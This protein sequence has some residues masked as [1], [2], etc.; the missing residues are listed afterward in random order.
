VAEITN[1]HYTAAFKKDGLYIYK[2]AKLIH[3]TSK[4]PDSTSWTLPIESPP[5]EANAVLSLP[6]DNKYL[7]FTHASFGSP[8]L[9]TFQRAIRKGYISTIPRLTSALISKHKPNP[10][11]T[12][13]GHLDR[14]RQGLDSTAAVPDAVATKPAT[15]TVSDESTYDDDIKNLPDDATAT[16]DDDPTVYVKLFTTADF[17][18][19]SRFPVTSSGSRYSYHLVSC[20]NGNI[21]VETMQRDTQLYDAQHLAATDHNNPPGGNPVRKR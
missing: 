8:V 20:Y 15:V 11:A 3:Y 5:L 4:S 6:S 17:D 14:R 2:G 9:S 19:T 13:K 10:E 16:I 18:A 7:Q 12:A 21:H 1:L